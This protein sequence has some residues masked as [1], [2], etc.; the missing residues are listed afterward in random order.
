MIELLHD[1]IG[2]ARMFASERAT[3]NREHSPDVG[4]VQQGIQSSVAYQ[5]TR[6]SKEHNSRFGVWHGVVRRG[7]QDMFVCRTLAWLIHECHVLVLRILG[8]KHA[9]EPGKKRAS[10]KTRRNRV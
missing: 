4:R 7:V 5:P 3:R 2:E 6:T 8:W 10:K 9:R 1:A